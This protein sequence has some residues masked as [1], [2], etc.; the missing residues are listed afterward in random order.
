MPRARIG[1]FLKRLD[2]GLGQGTLCTTHDCNCDLLSFISTPTLTTSSCDSKRTRPCPPPTATVSVP[3]AKHRAPGT[4]L[5]V[6]TSSEGHS[7]PHLCI[8]QLVLDLAPP[9]PKRHELATGAQREP[10]SLPRQGCQ[11]CKG[12]VTGDGD[13][14]LRDSER[15]RPRTNGPQGALST[16]GSAKGHGCIACKGGTVLLGEAGLAGDEAAA[17]DVPEKQGALVQGLSTGHEPGT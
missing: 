17:V 2:D 15:L 1:R 12:L 7:T 14:L 16:S 6:Y 9:K 3:T 8:D 4:W 10:R 13:L 5:Q 11:G